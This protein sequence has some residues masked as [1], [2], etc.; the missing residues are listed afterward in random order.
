[1]DFK[2]G[3]RNWV[4]TRFRGDLVYY[5]DTPI[6]AIMDAKSDEF[7]FGERVEVSVEKFLD[8]LHDRIAPWRLE[9]VGFRKIAG[10]YQQD[11]GLNVFFNDDV[12]E[13]Y[14]NCDG[15]C[16]DTYITTFTELL[17]LIRFLTPPVK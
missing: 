15:D 14:I 17:T 4:R 12:I 2:K 10:V 3:V 5:Q 11:S 13:S 1:M 16:I 6:E 9:E 8:L 7:V